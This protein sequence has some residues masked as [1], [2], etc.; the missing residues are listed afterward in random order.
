M[1]DTELYF[2]FVIEIEFLANTINV[3]VNRKLSLTYNFENDD[4]NKE[5]KSTTNI[6]GFE[7]LKK[8]IKFGYN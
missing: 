1:L 5:D 8:G 2:E 4:S 7:I 6:T 3:I